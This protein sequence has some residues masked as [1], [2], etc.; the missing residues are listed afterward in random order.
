VSSGLSVA[1]FSNLGMSFRDLVVVLH[2]VLPAALGTTSVSLLNTLW[3]FGLLVSFFSACRD[4]HCCA[5]TA[6]SFINACEGMHCP[7]NYPITIGSEVSSAMPGTD[8]VSSCAFHRE[9]Y[10]NAER[11]RSA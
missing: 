11:F 7:S 2:M 10:A 6:Q 5:I 1:L 8:F 3:D 4:A 9:T